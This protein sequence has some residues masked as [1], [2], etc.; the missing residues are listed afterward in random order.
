MQQ[1]QGPAMAGEGNRL[2]EWTQHLTE[3]LPTST[4]ASHKAGFN[5]QLGKLMK[6]GSTKDHQSAQTLGSSDSTNCQ[7]E[8]AH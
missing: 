2:M 7:S 8:K 6:E 4:R 1:G 3:Q 5:E